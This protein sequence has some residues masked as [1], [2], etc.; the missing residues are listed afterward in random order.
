MII[1]ELYHPIPKFSR[2]TWDRIN[3]KGSKSSISSSNP[4]TKL[5][6]DYLEY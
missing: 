1:E 6:I 4:S 3:Q 5:N 2:I